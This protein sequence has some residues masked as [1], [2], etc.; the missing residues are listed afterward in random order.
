[1][2]SP[3]LLLGTVWRLSKFAAQVFGNPSSLFRDDFRGNAENS[4]VMGATLTE[5]RTAI[6]ESRVRIKGGRFLSCARNVYQE[7]SA[8]FTVRPSRVR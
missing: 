4:A 1:M 6:D 3:T 8:R 7:T 2:P 5:L